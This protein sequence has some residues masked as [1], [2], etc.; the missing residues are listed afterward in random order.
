MWRRVLIHA[1]ILLPL[2][3]SPSPTHNSP[4]DNDCRIF[5]KKPLLSD[6]RFENC[7][8]DINMEPIELKAASIDTPP[9]AHFIAAKRVKAI[10]IVFI[11]SYYLFKL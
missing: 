10:D 2:L 5:L 3:P 1:A 11:N 7:H 4:D 8:V 9:F 6:K